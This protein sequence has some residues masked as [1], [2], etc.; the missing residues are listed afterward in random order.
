MPGPPENTK[1]NVPL[2]HSTHDM[3]RN[4]ILP[5]ER[6]VSVEDDAVQYIKTG[7]FS[8]VECGTVDSKVE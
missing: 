6:M 8:G 7:K 1:F 2:R 5:C 4:S 3:E